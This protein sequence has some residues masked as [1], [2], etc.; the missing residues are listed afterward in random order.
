MQMQPYASLIIVSADYAKPL[1][2]WCLDHIT[3]F[4]LYWFQSPMT[5]S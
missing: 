3:D 5:W 1:L 2:V 4:K